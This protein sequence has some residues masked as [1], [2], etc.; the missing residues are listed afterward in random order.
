MVV[1]FYKLLDREMFYLTAQAAQTSPQSASQ[2]SQINFM[3]RVQVRTY[4]RR[5]RIAR[6]AGGKEDANEEKKKK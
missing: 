4:A 1:S 2:I 3:R 5:R 6:P